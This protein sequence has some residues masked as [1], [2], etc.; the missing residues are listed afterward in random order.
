ML[1]NLS[2]MFQKLALVKEIESLENPGG[3][4]KRVALVPDDVGVLTSIGVEVFVESGAGEGVGFSD[5]EYLENGA[6]LQSADQ[7]YKDK[8]LIIKF[9][10]PALESIPQM[11]KNCTLLCMAHFNSFP[12]RATL[13]KEYQINVIAMEEILESPKIQTDEQIIARVAMAEVL[14]KF[15][16]ND[17]ISKLKVFVIGH[18]D[19]LAG[20]IRRA[21]NRNPFSLEILYSDVKFEELQE[22]GNETLYFYDGKE[23]NDPHAI[24]EKLKESGSHIFDLHAFELD[25]GKAAIAEYRKSHPPVEFGLR[26]IQCLHETGQAGAR[27][28]LKLLKENKPELNVADAKVAVLGYGN[29]ARGAMDEIYTHGVKNIHVLGRTQ[30]AEERI[31][32]WLKDVDLVVNGAELPI[33]LRGKTYLISNDHVK[34]SIPAGS[35]IIDLVSGSETNRSGV[36]AV[37]SAT[38]LTDP[39]FLQDEVTVSSLWGWPMMGMNRESTKKYSK[40]IVEVLMGRERLLEGLDALSPGVRRAFVC[41]PF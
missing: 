40:Q 19:R 23:F 26:R 11:K 38:F 12:Q 15:I 21:G 25:K 30:T 41:G 10:G 2:I 31:E 4:E 14:Q 5:K 32:H 6:I 8:D 3:M 1:Q 34:N 20:S 35:V 13:L 16:D 22:T 39:Y 17:T 36:E 7:I 28:G 24:L 27:Y 33:H 9:K 29:V 37:I 18:N